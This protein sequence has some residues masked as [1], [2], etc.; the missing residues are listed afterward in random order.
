MTKYVESNLIRDGHI[1]YE[2]RLHWIV[3]F[4]LK[5]LLTLFIA[6]LIARAASE[7]AI[8]NKRIIIKVGLISRH[9]LEMNLSKVESGGS[10]HLGAHPRVWL[11]HGYRYRRDERAVPLHCES[12]GV[13]EAISAATGIAGICTQALRQQPAPGRPSLSNNPF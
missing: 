8:T 5:A 13:Q 1:A 2:T 6:P 11:H 9:T 7:F 4:S 10:G 3:F 12:D